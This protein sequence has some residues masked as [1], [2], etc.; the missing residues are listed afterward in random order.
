M[1]EQSLLQVTFGVLIFQVEKLKNE[2]VFYRL[3]W[4]QVI[5]RTRL[6]LLN[7]HG[8]LVPGQCGA[9][10]KQGIDL[11]VKLTN[12]P[13]SPQGF[14]L[15]KFTCMH[16][17]DRKQP[18]VSRPGQ[19][20]NCEKLFQLPSMELTLDLPDTVWKILSEG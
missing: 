14:C 3:L 7:Q 8:C 13:S 9:L 6:S 5:F 20:E 2:R 12:R 17:F 18:H 1:I 19:R 16:V 4:E 10:V 15:I 11:P